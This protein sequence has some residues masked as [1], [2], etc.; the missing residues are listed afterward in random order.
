MSLA[1][2]T[3]RPRT[4]RIHVAVL[5]AYTVAALLLTWPLVRHFGTHV[6][7]DGI[8][9]PAL[10]W[11]LWWIKARLVDQLQPA[12]FNMGWMFHPIQI[13][14]AF[15]TL[16]PL[17]G[18]ISIPLQVAFGLVPAVNLLAILSFVLSGYGVYLLVR[19]TL[20]PHVDGGRGWPLHLAGFAAGFLYAFAAPKLFYAA[21]GQYNIMSSQWMPFCA[22]YLV[23]LLRARSMSQAL[24]A[25]AMA[26]LF[27]VL[28]AWAELTFA[29]FMLLF[30]GLGAAAAFVISLRDRRRFGPLVGGFAAMGALFVVGMLPYLAAMIPDLLREGDFFASGGGFTDLYSAD[31]A[32]FLLPTR[33]HP[34]VGDWVATLPFPNDKGQQAFVGYVALILAVVG[35]IWMWRRARAQALFWGAATLCFW[36]LSLGPSLRWMGRDLGVPGPFA[37]VSLLPF[38]NGNRYPSRYVVPLL[39]CLSMLLAAGLIALMQRPRL[40]ST[41]AGALLT[42]GV[43]GVIALESLSIPLPLSNFH[44]PAIYAKLAQEPGNQAVLEL[45]TGWRNGAR[46]LGRSDILIMMQQWR[47]TAHAKPRLGGNTSRNPPQKFQY[48]TE[49]PL[50]GDL[51]ALMNSDQPGLEEMNDRVA[52]MIDRHAPIAAQ[53]LADLGVGWVTLHEEK[54]TDPLIRFVEEALPLDLVDVQ[55]EPDWSGAP[56]TIRL[57][58]VKPAEPTLPRTFTLADADAASS[59]FAWLGEGW[60]PVRG[61][62]DRYANR[63][64]ASLLMPLPADGAILTLTP[65]ARQTP[66]EVRVN[67][68]ALPLLPSAG[69][70]DAYALARGQASES[71]STVE[72]VFA[73]EGQTVQKLADV[74]SAIGTT[75]ST[76]PAG[77]ALLA[78]GAGEPTGDFAQLWVNGMDVAPG[79]RGFNLAALDAQGA[80]I[81]A[82]RFDTFAGEDESARMAAWLR[83]WPPG[84]I[85]MGAVADEASYQL[86]DD[87]IAALATIGVASDGLDHFRRSHAFIGVAGAGPGSALADQSDVHSASVWLGAPVDGER[88]YGPINEVTLLPA[89]E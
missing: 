43:V 69:D 70:F 46:V 58:R 54:A 60:S 72:I 47:Q 17:N 30:I 34:W 13:N 79:G 56:E 50:V 9:D 6:P 67:G 3:T 80:L 38:F 84:T 62:D 31:L 61:A 89:T 18:L 39:L 87:A 44:I 7:G 25:G 63:D 15:Y 2:R 53:E 48:F 74:P 36:L 19:F 82:S 88:G 24:R 23:A 59:A 71:V 42:A 4:W 66:P 40:R 49:H 76:L 33:L 57:Y 77:V 35:I 75:G 26:A 20:G 68:E 73:D 32:G 86:T 37:L 83:A 52:D 22:L 12:I 8:D 45:P 1:A 16:T 21:L 14:L 51:I 65:A 81:E 29:S 41:R 11:N 64:R 55:Q 5:L 27:L 28:Q 85:V 78:R 10:A